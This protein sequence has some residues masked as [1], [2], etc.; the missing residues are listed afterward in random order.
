MSKNVSD[1]AAELEAK[2]AAIRA[3]H[4][5]CVVGGC[6]AAREKTGPT[7]L[8]DAA[9]A[10]G[11][12]A[13]DG[14]PLALN[15]SQVIREIRELRRE[16]DYLRNQLD[17][18]NQHLV[19]TSRQ[20]SEEHEMCVEQ[21][22]LR[23]EDI[24]TIA[25]LRARLDTLTRPIDGVEE[26]GRIGWEAWQKASGFALQPREDAEDMAC[27]NAEAQAIASRVIGALRAGLLGMCDG[28]ANPVRHKFAADCVEAFDD[29]VASL[30]IEPAQRKSFEEMAE[31]APPQSAVLAS[32]EPPSMSPLAKRLLDASTQ[33]VKAAV[34]EHV[35]AGRMH[36]HPEADDAE[37]IDPLP[38][39]K[40]GQ[41][42]RHRDGDID[43]VA[44]ISEGE[45]HFK[46]LDFSMS[47]FN[48]RCRYTN[49]WTLVSDEPS[50]KREPF[51]L[52]TKWEAENEIAYAQA[53][54]DRIREIERR[55]EAGGL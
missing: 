1:Q 6:G 51:E 50:P 46:H 54:R 21:R 47:L 42:W 41:L 8:A 38:V 26:L 45:A 2:L 19:A 22:L 12:V 53:I 27:D 11:Q 24:N 55:L 33:A 20:V 43:E 44:R 49:E 3:A 14:T 15:W 36:A 5:R 9:E 48:D 52:P 37:Q 7:W 13:P 4:D 34:A 10:L 32:T 30:K 29:V 39:V 40:V 17:E 28:D 16:R 25:D 35:A 23:R 18:M 31:V